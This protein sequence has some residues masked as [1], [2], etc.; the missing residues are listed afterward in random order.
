MLALR[1][2][3]CSLLKIRYEERRYLINEIDLMPNDVDKLFALP[4]ELVS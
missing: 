2:G 3:P 4:A 1:L